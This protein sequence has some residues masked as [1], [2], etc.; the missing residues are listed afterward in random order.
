MTE[1][2]FKL[3][4][5]SREFTGPCNWRVQGL[6]AWLHPVVKWCHAVSF[7]FSELASF[8]GRVSTWGGKS[9]CSRFTSQEPN[10]PS[11]EST[12]FPVGGSRGS[13]AASHWP[14][15]VMCP[16]SVRV[17]QAGVTGPS[18]SAWAW[19]PLALKQR[20]WRD[21][22]CWFLKGKNRSG[23]F[24]TP[25]S[26]YREARRGSYSPSSTFC[27]YR[28][29][30]KGLRNP[31]API[32]SLP[33]TW[34]LNSCPPLR[35]LCPAGTSAELRKRTPLPQFWDQRKEEKLMEEPQSVYFPFSYFPLIRRLMREGKFHPPA[36]P[37]KKN[38]KPKPQNQMSNN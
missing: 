33:C 1:T 15:W 16:T 2:S 4:R 12:R 34:R 37:K 28:R 13:R 27:F 10:I 25:G 24:R 7:I 23:A 6:K 30:R 8:P 11:G 21:E 5:Q 14:Y 29:G 3:R 20:G 38:N 26:K 36:R 17:R 32:Q 19:G 18:L 9:F 22:E 35:T 31:L